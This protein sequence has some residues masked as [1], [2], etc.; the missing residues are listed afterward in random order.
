MLAL[1][2]TRA[3]DKETGL[4]QILAH[5]GV[6]ISGVIVTDPEHSQDGSDVI[7][8]AFSKHPLVNPLLGN[9]LYLDRPRPVSGPR[10]QPTGGPRVEAVAFSGEHAFM[11]GDPNRKQYRFPLMVTVE[12][13]DIK[14]VSSERGATRAVVAGDSVFLDNAHI[15]YLAN[16]DFAVSAMDWLLDRTQLVEGL[17]AHPVK[18]WNV[19]MTKAQFQQAQWILLAGMPGGVL[20]L[21]G[22][23][24]IRRRK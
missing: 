2:N 23:V 10:T 12:R 16:R 3:L 24:W 15:D 1:F 22:L 14:G 21:G 7:V 8:S 20:L 5:W 6:R 18:E 11:E 13:G 4:E 17:G 19:I 9:G